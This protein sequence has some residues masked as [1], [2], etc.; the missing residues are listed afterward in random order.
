MPRHLPS[1]CRGILSG[2][3]CGTRLAEQSLH[4]GVQRLLWFRRLARE[5]SCSEIGGTLCIRANVGKR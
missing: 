5:A 1:E 4:V 3:S 2:N